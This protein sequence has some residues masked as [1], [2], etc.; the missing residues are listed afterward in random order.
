MPR[1]GRPDTIAETIRGR[2]YFSA[3][4]VDGGILEGVGMVDTTIDCVDG[5]LLIEEA[6]GT[7]W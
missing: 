2:K 1:R 4:R 7:Q 3:S 5:P 6:G